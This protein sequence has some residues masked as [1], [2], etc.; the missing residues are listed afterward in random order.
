MHTQQ[1][2]NI[3]PSSSESESSCERLSPSLSL[4]KGFGKCSPLVEG[5]GDSQ[6]SFFCFFFYRTL[7][8]FVPFCCCFLL[9]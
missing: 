5:L 8:L 3:S 6:I 2:S 4:V 7:V 1:T 9:S